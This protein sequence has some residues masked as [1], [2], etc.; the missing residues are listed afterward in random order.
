[1]RWCQDQVKVSKSTKLCLVIF[2]EGFHQ[3]LYALPHLIV[4]VLI[5]FDLFTWI[6]YWYDH[7]TDIRGH[8]YLISLQLLTV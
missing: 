8:P 5:N 7:M 3:S 1:M 2:D 4:I 6:N